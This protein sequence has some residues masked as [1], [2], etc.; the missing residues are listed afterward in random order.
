MTVGKNDLAALGEAIEN[1]GDTLEKKISDVNDKVNKLLKSWPAYENYFKTLKQGI[2]DL[3]GE[4][5]ELKES[6][7]ALEDKI[8]TY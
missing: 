4:I 8:S 1:L 2:D 3:R 6:L 7:Q 5:E